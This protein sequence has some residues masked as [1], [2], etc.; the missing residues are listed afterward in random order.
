M[1][2]LIQTYANVDVATFIIFVLKKMK[3]ALLH[4]QKTNKAIVIQKRE[5]GNSLGTLWVHM[6]ELQPQEG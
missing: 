5:R 1:W 3:Q 6:G 4:R 2:Q